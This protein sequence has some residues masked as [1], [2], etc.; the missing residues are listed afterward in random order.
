ML[1]REARAFAKVG[2]LFK[3]LS[4]ADSG[5]QAVT[6]SKTLSL[7]QSGLQKSLGRRITLLAGVTKTDAGTFSG[8]FQQY[9]NPRLTKRFSFTF[10]ENE[11]SFKPLNPDDIERFSERDDEA[12]F[13][14]TSK[15]GRAG[16]SLNCKV[17]QCGGRCLRGGES[18]RLTPTE[19]QKKLWAAA[20]G[21]NLATKPDTS[22]AKKRREM[23]E[24]RVRIA[25]AERAEAEKASLR[26]KSKQ[27]ARSINYKVDRSDPD[28]LIKLGAD[29]SAKHLKLRDIPPSARENK[30]FEEKTA[31]GKEIMQAREAGDMRRVSD[32]APKF[33]AKETAYYKVQNERID[34]MDAQYDKFREEIIKK[35]GVTQQ[36]AEK[37]IER[38][39]LDDSLGNSKNQVKQDFTD[40]YLLT[41]GKGFGRLDEIAQTSERAYASRS[42]M[43]NVGFRVN[44]TT[45]LHE[46][47][48]HVE[49][50]SNEVIE[51]SIKWRNSRATGAPEQLSKLS[52]GGRYDE[53]E[54]AFPG[55]YV[56]PYVGKDYGS[57]ATEVVSVGIEN[58]TDGR[59]MK[60][61]KEKD[62]GH[63]NYILG[64]ILS[65]D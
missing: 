33:F 63:L 26:K 34:K 39:T 41:G 37:A 9:V 64:V 52:P 8:E 44:R 22:L 42:G 50:G 40:F 10:G 65:E 25:E 59:S 15:S 28:A 54:I 19:E 6:D 57:G 21:K 51:A 27:S 61:F 7:V 55:K 48:H 17:E 49:Y 62:E 32:I 24:N 30:L 38:I 58:F 16:K 2:Q 47:G 13:A 12:D 4:F 56:T 36:Q 60:N 46:L 14:R 5:K 3:E 31:L 43:I 11:I 18:C 35:H 29:F 20:S 1:T 23:K 45:N 53:N